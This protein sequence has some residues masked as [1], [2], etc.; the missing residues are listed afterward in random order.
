MEGKKLSAVSDEEILLVLKKGKKKK[1]MRSCKVTKYYFGGLLQFSMKKFL[2]LFPRLN[3][4][5]SLIHF[6]T[7]ARTHSPNDLL[8]QLRYLPPSLSLSHAHTPILGL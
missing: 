1:K 2:F 5:L 6:L 8:P 4:S 7:H 3:L